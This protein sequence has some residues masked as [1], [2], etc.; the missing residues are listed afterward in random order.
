MMRGCR[1]LPLTVSKLILMPSALALG[2]KLLAHQQIICLCYYI[3]FTYF[4][5]LSE[6][7]SSLIA[8]WVAYG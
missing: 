8:F 5:Y 3:F 4:K 7:I 1:S 2:E 6:A